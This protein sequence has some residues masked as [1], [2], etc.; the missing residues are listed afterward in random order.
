MYRQLKDKGVELIAINEI[1]T[2]DVIKAYVKES[3]VT[4][5]IAMNPAAAKGEGVAKKYGVQGYPTSYVI[6]VAGKVVWRGVP[7]DPSAIRAVLEKIL[8]PGTQPK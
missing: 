3:G 4:F 5:R 1:D 2:L 7:S 8:G 6:D